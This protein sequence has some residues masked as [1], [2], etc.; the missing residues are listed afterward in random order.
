MLKHFIT[1]PLAVNTYLLISKK[2]CVVIDPGESTAI[3]EFIKEN[4]LKLD[5]ILL[6]HAHFDHIGG[7]EELKRKTVSALA[8]HKDDLPLYQM[9]SRVGERYG[10]NITTKLPS[11]DLL[12]PS[13]T[14]TLCWEEPIEV[15]HLPGHTPG[16][17][18]YIWKNYI[19]SG[20]T[21]FNGGIGR[22]DLEGGDMNT[23]L[24]SIHKL[25]PL[26]KCKLI[27]PGHG[28]WTTIE[29]ELRENI[30]LK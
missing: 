27:C 6:T 12:F 26:A 18:A 17:V 19:F 4:A 30:Y 1:G 10:F 11:P 5:W 8:L 22:T 23:L 25:I 29:K 13:Q 3:L 16:G 28:T 14:Y 24:A 7:V 20:D 15:I 9:A 2:V 21:L